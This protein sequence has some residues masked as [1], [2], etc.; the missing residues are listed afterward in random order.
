MPRARSRSFALTAHEL[1][2]LPSI[3]SKI[4]V[5]MSASSK[6]VSKAIT[7]DLPVNPGELEKM[8]GGPGSSFAHA[9]HIA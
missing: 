4:E 7:L 2:T 6:D 1:V 9:L 3:V 5:E 8:R